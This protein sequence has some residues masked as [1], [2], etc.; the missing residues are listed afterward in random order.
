MY[1]QI[2]VLCMQLGKCFINLLPFFFQR[3]PLN[4]SSI[5]S[6]L[7]LVVTDTTI[8]GFLVIVWFGGWSLSP[9][10]DVI[11]LRFLYFQNETYQS[12][13]LLI[14]WICF[15]EGWS[16]SRTNKWGSTLTAGTTLS[17][18]SRLLS[19]TCW[20]LAALN[21]KHRIPEYLEIPQDSNHEEWKYLFTYLNTNRTFDWLLLSI[22]LVLGI[23]LLYSTEGK[24]ESILN[25]RF[26]E[27]K[28]LMGLL[29]SLLLSTSTI[30][31][32]CFLP[33]FITVS[34]WSILVLDSVCGV[35]RFPNSQPLSTVC[36]ALED[37]QVQD[38]QKLM[39]T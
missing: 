13:P 19:L 23:T 18:Q 38:R 8:T 9:D 12:I 28:T 24:R 21:G 31:S 11:F 7:I 26:E 17:V 10:T 36:S 15:S 1:I 16:R 30:V 35:L 20:L 25:K 34:S 4:Q 2:T 32:L 22:G 27:K 14:P 39:L 37:V 3:T 6:L 5:I 33:P 29:T